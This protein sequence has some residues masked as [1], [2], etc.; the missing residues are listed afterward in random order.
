M[1]MVVADWAVDE[2]GQVILKTA[3]H[4]TLYPVVDEIY[5][6]EFEKKN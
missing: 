5:S 6:A 3:D 4:L 2:K 1:L